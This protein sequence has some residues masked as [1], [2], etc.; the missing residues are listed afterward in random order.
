VIKAH[1]KDVQRIVEELSVLITFE[2]G[3]EAL[4]EYT[5]QHKR[6]RG[7]G[8]YYTIPPTKNLRLR[9]ESGLE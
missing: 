6:D 4:T 9:K 8:L 1:S 2:D 3:T 5:E 7:R